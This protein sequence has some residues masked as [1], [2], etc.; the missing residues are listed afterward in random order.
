M[1][2]NAPMQRIRATRRQVTGTTLVGAALLASPMSLRDAS[3]QASGG[4]LNV[5]NQGDIRSL[6]P[7]GSNLSVWSLIR[8]NIYDTLF[9]V[10]AGTGDL[11]PNLAT[12]WSFSAPTTL[13]ITLRDDVSFHSGV[14]FTAD[15][16]KFTID[17]VIDPDTAT[18]EFKTRLAT[19]ESVEVVDPTHVLFHLT[20]PNASLPFVLSGYFILC[21]DDLETIV[22]GPPN[23]TGAF[24]FGEWKQNDSLSIQR[25]DEYWD[26]VATLDGVVFKVIPEAETRIASL[27][28]GQIDFIADVDLMDVPELQGTSGIAVSVTPPS[29]GFWHIYMN[30]RKAPFDNAK[31]RQ[32]VVT[33]FDRQTFIDAFAAGLANV[34]NT[35]LYSENWAYNPDV[36]SMYAF[37]MDRAAELLVE[38]GYPK[39]EGLEFTFIYPPGYPD[40]KNGSLIMQAAL[41]ELGAKVDVQEVELATW[42]QMIVTDA[43]YDIAWDL[44]GGGISDP[45]VVYGSSVFLT[46]SPDNFLGLTEE[47]MPEYAE[48]IRQGNATTD[49]EARKEI[50]LQVQQL[51]A[52]AIPDI[53]VAHRSVAYAATDA[54]QGFSPSVSGRVKFN[55]VSL[56]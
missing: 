41:T 8:W 28:S 56:S 16:V 13:A 10:D 17:Y 6:D 35:P 12:E 37:D 47:M 55:S 32:A 31:V 25:F 29:N 1:Q 49:Q 26:T 52:D 7:Y 48:L 20:E 2:S 42:S 44:G 3:G 5:G 21:K 11:T 22:S 33:A 14:P 30:N 43:D 51:W 18:G 23:G 4:I 15:D 27:K 9:W 45:G 39:G 36:A 38:A 24:S 34:T 46:P 50:Y 40:F 53:I 19:L 54:V